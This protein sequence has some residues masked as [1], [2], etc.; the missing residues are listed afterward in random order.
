MNPNLSILEHAKIVVGLPPRTPST[1]TPDY[2]SMKG[3]ARC[4]VIIVVDNATTVTGSAVTLKQA[5]AVAGTGEKALALP[6][7]FR[8]VDIDAADALA[9]F[10]VTADTFTTDPTNNK[11]LLYVA[12]VK[13]E[14]LDLD[15]G[16]DCIRAGVGDATAA[17]LAVL[18]VLYGAR[19]IVSGQTSP[20]AILD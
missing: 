12:D 16:F 6:S 17:V 19:Y 2:V 10:A 9:E 8:N 4:A 5:Q 14:D 3:Y 7:A 20:S 1:S 11:N 15:N 13:A 18:Y